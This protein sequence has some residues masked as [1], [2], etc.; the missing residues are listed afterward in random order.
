MNPELKALYAIF[1]VFLTTIA[2]IPYIV[3]TWK[4][5]G[6]NEVRPTVSG[7]MCWT[8]SDAAI[9]AAMIAG[10]TIS[11]QM[12]PYV[13]GG[14]LVIALSLRKSFRIAQMRGEITSWKDAFA[15]WDGKDTACIIIV[16]TAVVV[17]GIKHDP[18]Y[19]I[20]LTVFSTSIGTWAVARHLARDPYRE[21]L[22]AWVLFL[23]GGYFGVAAIPAWN[24]TGAV[25]PILFVGI[26]GMMVV[27]CMRRFQSQF[28]F[29]KS[30]DGK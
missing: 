23:V 27:L 18:D 15:D 2:F 3:E 19:A 4:T 13:F 26:Q 7:F 30:Q 29:A 28:R 22:V 25:A 12:V 20:Y 21:S 14:T 24:V 9:L 6:C 5:K 11:W 8:L 10:E 16:V 1:S 17:W